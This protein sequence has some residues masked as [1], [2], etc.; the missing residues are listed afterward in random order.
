MLLSA[1]LGRCS[2]LVR[3]LLAYR[4]LVPRDRWSRDELAAHQRRRLARLIR[5]AARRSPFYRNLYRGLRT[6]EALPLK[7]L[8]TVTKEAVMDNFDRLVTDPRIRLREV[9]D[10][11][12]RA[13]GDALYLDEYRVMSTSGTTG[14][15]GIFLYS[16][17]EWSVVLA[18]T[19]RWQRMI[20][21][22]PRFPSRVR[23]A[24]IG[25]AKAAHVSYRLTASGDIGLYKFLTLD[26]AAPIADLVEALNGFKP[27]A[28]LSYPSVAALLAA[29][30]LDGRLRIRP[31]VVSTHSE[32][33]TAEMAAIIERA[34]GTA[35]F[36]HYGLT[37]H[38]NCGCACTYRRGIHLLEDLFIA[39]IVDERD[40][41]VP[42]GT[43]GFK[44]L[45]TNLYNFTQPLIRY[46]VSDMLT[47]AP[48]ACAC[49]RPFR[50]VSRIEGRN[51][52]ILYL[53]ADGGSKVPVHPL[54]F[55]DAME[56]FS[57]VRQYQVVEE[58]DGVHLRV[59]AQA[60]ADKER[61]ETLLVDRLR[62]GLVSAGVRD[63][64]IRVDFIDA[65]ERADD[66][67]GKTRLIVALPKGQAR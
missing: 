31:R 14:L 11:L 58:P 62:A 59:V 17:R 26:A 13:E 33:L 34:W 29:E 24:T 39:E 35:P 7:A 16:R 25:A 49:G 53:P 30:Q 46:E 50:L 21:V 40:R 45:L 18:D 41:P 61:L 63:P 22:M 64:K 8:P 67:I 44:L 43:P 12:D 2:E 42:P 23:I 54:H 4:V 56:T 15:K 27:E 65:L 36:D 37:E 51:D 57:D 66:A 52:D 48:H 3:V 38:P 28:L 60:G 32:L 9:R 10:H 6:D 47:V 55:Y 19:L 20:G 1:V 5:H